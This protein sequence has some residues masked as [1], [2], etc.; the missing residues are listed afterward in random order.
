MRL[1]ALGAMSPTWLFEIREAR[2]GDA[3][4]LAEIESASP[5]RGTIALGVTPV[6]SYFAADQ[7]TPGLVPLVACLQGRVVGTISYHLYD[8]LL[9]DQLARVAYHSRLR[10]AP[11]VR[12]Q[13]LAT[14]LL[15]E[16]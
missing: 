13:G 5:E 10:V 2:T 1:I 12:G 9:G 7:T 6:A 4:R 8:T 3:E 15:R 14:S 11:E 16:A